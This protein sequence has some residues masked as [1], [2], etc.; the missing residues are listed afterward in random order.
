MS[1]PGPVS[2][3]PDPNPRKPRLKVP[4]GA[5]DTHF[6]IMGP[7]HLFPY[8]ESRWHTPPAAPV[9]HY[10]AVAKVLGFERGVAVLPT[11]HGLDPSSVINAIQKSDGRL[12]G[13]IRANPNLDD[14]E[15]K[16]LHAAGIR[17]VRVELRSQG[18]VAGAFGMHVDPRKEDGLVEGDGLDRIITS[19]SRAGWVV[20][21]HIDPETLIELA[22]KIRRMPGPVLI[23][24]F[25]SIDACLG[26]DQPA[27]RT[28][29]DLAGE[30]HVW[31][32][33]ASTYRM[34]IRGATREQVRSIAR[35]V[36]ASSPDRATWGT[37]W[38][39]PGI[40]RPGMMPNDGDLVDTLL[41]F[42]PDETVRHKLLVE[43]PKRLYDFD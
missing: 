35:I 36:H 23:E 14:A 26:T 28:L 29:I 7:P 18:T 37:D 4:P 3:P 11:G 27:L 32:K 16:K 24:N 12:R 39:H 13:M 15:I 20:G 30:P 10:L 19:A 34:M 5:W 1:Q 9:E 33:T 25:A 17:A 43:N 42:V 41:D 40:F 8:A 6:H 38:P 2:F 22:D 21:L 31:L